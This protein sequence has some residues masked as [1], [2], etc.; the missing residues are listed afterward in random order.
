MRMMR[1]FPSS[2]NERYI[3]ELTD[4]LRDGKL[5]IY[6]T[7]TVYAIGCDAMNSR[8]IERVCRIKDIDPRRQHL[9]ITC[10]DISQAAEY[11]RIDNN[12]F[13]LLR[14]SLPGPFTFILPASTTLP[15]VF[16]GRKEVG[17]RIPDNAIARRLAE[18]LGHPLLTTTVAWEEA[19][20]DI[21]IPEA[22]ERHY[23]ALGVDFIIDAGEGGTE[24][25]TI[26]NLT[27]SSAEPEIIRQGK[28]TL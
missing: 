20:D 14:R 13:A 8:A 6:P 21:T 18:A 23:E 24:G 7:D 27:D 10:A 22:I 9:S 17:I 1:M 3:D 4:A 26:V 15:K 12:A 19:D 16:K 25:S 5:I 11:A 2:I 28:G